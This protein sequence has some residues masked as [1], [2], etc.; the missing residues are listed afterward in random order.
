MKY[1]NAQRKWIRRPRRLLSELSA[2]SS[3]ER[4]PLA[5]FAIKEQKHGSLWCEAWA[6]EKE[7]ETRKTNVINVKSLPLQLL[8]LKEHSK[9]REKL[10][11]PPPPLR[12][13]TSTF[14]LFSGLATISAARNKT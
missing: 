1:Q 14:F 10:F 6:D 3:C 11:L 12:R 8:P 2:K 13:K 9:S 7:E 4:L 5:G